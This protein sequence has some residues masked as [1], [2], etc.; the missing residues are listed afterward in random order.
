MPN[1]PLEP[2][3]SLLCLAC[4]FCCNGVLH[5]Y[6]VVKP[7]KIESVRGLGLTVETFG[8]NLGFRQPCPLY[9]EGRCSDYPNRPSTCKTYRCALLKKYLA[10]EITCELGVQIIQR[11]EEL[12][13]TVLEQLPPGYSFAQLRKE[14]DQDW[15]SGRGLF[16]SPELRQ[17]NAEFLLTMAKL[18]RYLQ[19]YFGKKPKETKT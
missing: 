18:M 10:G 16:G 7:S 11:A 14:I 4:G 5:A 1:Q 12:L 17:A 19:R 8:D 6:A 9:R 13:A 3:G 2:N 15:N